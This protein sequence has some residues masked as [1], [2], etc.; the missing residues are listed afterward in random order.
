MSF[1]AKYQR[2]QQQCGVPKDKPTVVHVAEPA[3]DDEQPAEDEPWWM[4][5]PMSQYLR[6][7]PQGESCSVG[8]PEFTLLDLLIAFFLPFYF[9]VFLSTRP[10]FFTSSYSSPYW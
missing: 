10:P 3:E 1:L 2:L 6:V 5:K 4:T 9:S 8:T 7:V